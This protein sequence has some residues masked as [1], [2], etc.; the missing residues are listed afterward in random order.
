MPS[1]NMPHFFGIRH[2]SPCGA[3]ELVK[4]LDKTDPDM[5]LIE[6]P[7]DL[8]DM[9]KD[10][11]SP[12]TKPPFAIMAYS[13]TVPIHTILY[14]MAVYSPE[15]QAVLWSY[16]HKRKCRFIDLPSGVFLAMSDQRNSEQSDEHRGKSVYQLMEEKLGEQ[17]E[18]WWERHFEHNTNSDAYRQGTYEYGRQLR[19]HD[20]SDNYHYAENKIREC[21]MKS[22]IEAAL[23]E[24][25]AEKTVV[26]TGAYHTAGIKECT[27]LTTD[28][29][30]K[31]PSISA[32]STLMPYS[33][34]R[35]SSRSG[36]GAG[37]KAPQYYE[38]VWDSLNNN[39]PGYAMYSYI[40]GIADY[41]R[42]NGGITSSAE[43]MEAVR[44]AE[45]LA[46][47]K[48][49]SVP[50]LADLRDSVV[51]CI[52]HGHFSEV[53]QAAA[54]NEIGIKIGQLPEGVSRTALQEDFYGQ[55]KELKLDKYRTLETHTLELDLREN[56]RV[57]SEKAAFLDL[58][59]SFFLQRLCVLGIG[60][61]V[62][63]HK[64]QDRATWAEAWD[65][66]WT[67]EAEIQIVEAALKGDT[68]ELAAAFVFDEKL[69]DSKNIGDVSAVLELA[70]LCGMEKTV[71][72]AV[73]VLQ[74]VAVDAASVVEIGNTAENISAS[75]K[76][77]SIR[78]LDTDQFIPVLEQMFYRGCVILA[79]SCTCDN[80]A[81]RELIPAIAK[82]NQVQIDNDFIDSD[83]WL[84]VLSEISQRDDINTMA[85]GFATAILLERGDI[86]SANLAAEVQRRLSKGIPAD[87]GALWFEG[88]SMKNR[89][90][91][92]ARLS[93]WEKLS[94]YI[95]TLDDEEFKRALVFLRRAFSVFSSYEKDQIA[96]NLGEIWGVNAAEA[97][98]I[99]N[100]TLSEQQ[101]EM[102]DGL[103]D[104][105]FGDL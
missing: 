45:A 70:C 100:D 95:D 11:C 63:R 3:Y 24:V 89:H 27:A 94:E 56:I 23:T 34:Y 31:L 20:N 50:T 75:I 22:Q 74:S 1:Q 92:I 29:L 21:F 79:Q 93:L 88:L 82:L 9:I 6:G 90:A 64:K 71:R 105:D 84:K 15:Y 40:S 103:E 62:N 54:F 76:Y 85:S 81:V 38:L 17:Q 67:P 104:F 18:V 61:A 101:Q 52:G 36:Y 87:L 26:I 57:K 83:E 80:N 32:K 33:Y 37:N 7:S 30:Q 60:F 66:S 10:M 41:Q 2:L 49:S 5:V 46:A 98:E 28:E 42:K 19:E 72:L 58:E 16:R 13:E 8:S 99:L 35:L 51:T 47:M 65:L 4:F 73:N 43:V 77:G 97:S 59:R 39:D 25:A 12:M 86:S 91:L 68:I 96:E 55:I 78:K 53:A 69:N 44:L 102:L 48:N 14:P